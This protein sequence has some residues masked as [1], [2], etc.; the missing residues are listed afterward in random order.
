M[1]EA[2]CIYGLPHRLPQQTQP[3]LPLD[4]FTFVSSSKISPG[5]GA[6]TANMNNWHL[7]QSN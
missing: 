4:L 6:D 3:T 2:V 7:R 1:A 5:A